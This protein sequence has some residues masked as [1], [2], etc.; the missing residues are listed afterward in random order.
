MAVKDGPFGPRLQRE[1]AV[2][3]QPG[4]EGSECLRPTVQD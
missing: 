3:E 2:G 4:V 1:P